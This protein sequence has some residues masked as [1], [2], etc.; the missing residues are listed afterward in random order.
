MKLGNTGYFHCFH[1]MLSP[2]SGVKEDFP[3]EP[4]R[5]ES[6]GCR[7]SRSRAK[8]QRLTSLGIRLEAGGG[9][10]GS[11]KPRTGEKAASL[12]SCKSGGALLASAK[13][14]LGIPIASR[15]AWCSSKTGRARGL[16][17]GMWPHPKSVGAAGVCITGAARRDCGARCCPAARSAQRLR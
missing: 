4:S 9:V 12:P 11:L 17:F 13:S 1:P 7:G 10:T 2:A 14:S 5:E 3:G 8:E 6:N 15:E 16:I